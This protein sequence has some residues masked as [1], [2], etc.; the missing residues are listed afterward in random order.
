MVFTGA[1][2]HSR[3]RHRRECS[4]QQLICSIALYYQPCCFSP[5]LLPEILGEYLLVLI[6]PTVQQCKARHQLLEYT[7]GPHSGIL[8]VKKGNCT[9]HGRWRKSM[10]GGMSVKITQASLRRLVTLKICFLC[11]VLPLTPKL[12]FSAFVVLNDLLNRLGR[13]CHT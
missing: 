1:I 10:T 9:V 11:N 8:M 12:Y 4:S 13:S 7:N 2:V 6:S 3:N 5:Y